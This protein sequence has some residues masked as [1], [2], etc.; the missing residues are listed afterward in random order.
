MKKLPS[1]MIPTKNIL[2]P[3]MP[4]LTHLEKPSLVKVE[5]AIKKWNTTSTKLNLQKISME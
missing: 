1:H 2:G 4:S 3:H 5:R